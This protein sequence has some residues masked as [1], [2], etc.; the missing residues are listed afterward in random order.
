M[1]EIINAPW[2]GGIL[3]GIIMLVVYI[4]HGGQ[5]FT[6]HD[7]RITFNSAQITENRQQVAELSNRQNE[8]VI[9]L[10]KVTIELHYLRAD[11]AEIDSKIDKLLNGGSYD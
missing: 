7:D 10:S 6:N 3:V 4:V 1:K 9:E 11:V 8:L 2:T 5:Q